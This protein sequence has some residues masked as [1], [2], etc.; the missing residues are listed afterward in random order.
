MLQ[1]SPSISKNLI[2]QKTGRRRKQSLRF[3]PFTPELHAMIENAMNRVDALL[4][5]RMLEKLPRHKY[6]FYNVTFKR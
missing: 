1:T 4:E 5:A 2:L 3:D 6:K